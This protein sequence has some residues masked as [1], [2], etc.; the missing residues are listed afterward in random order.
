MKST[1][2]AEG[3]MILVM[4]LLIF[5]AY[6]R[7]GNSVTFDSAW[8]IHT[9]MSLLR[10]H[11]ADLD[12]YRG[13]I[14]TI[15]QTH[16]YATETINGHIYNFYPIGSSIIALPLVA[17]A[18]QFAR[19]VHGFDLQS[20]LLHSFA[21]PI[22]LLIASFLVAL[23]AVVLYRLARL[24]L[25]ISLALLL[26]FIFAFCTSAWSTASRVLWQHTASLLMLSL[27]LYLT[28]LARR[29][30]ALIQFISLPLALSYTIRP[31]NS[32]SIVVFTLY[33]FIAYR[34]YLVRYLLWALLVVVP[35]I[36]FNESIYHAL[37]SPYY[38]QYQE[39]SFA[40][41]LPALVGQ[42]LSPS[43]GLL[44]YSPVLLLSLFG[45]LIKI[46]RKQIDYLDVCL[47]S[48]VV[49]HWLAISIWPMWWGGWSYGPRLFT[50]MLA[51]FFYFMIP[52][53]V[54]APHWKRWRQAVLAVGTLLL[55]LWSF[56]IHYRGAT[57]PATLE[58]N[59]KPVYVD[60]YPDRLWDW[61]DAQFVRGLK[62]G[63]PTDLALSGIPILYFDSATYPLLGTNQLRLRRFDVS[64]AVIAPPEPGWLAISDQQVI[65]PELARLFAGV[66]AEAHF[67]TI[68]DHVPYSLYHFDLGQRLS[69][70]ALQSRQTVFVSS[71][72]QS[73]SLP[74]QLGKVVQ[75]IGYDV[76]PSPS[77][78]TTD[79]I[80]YW[81]ALQAVDAPLKLVVQ[82][83]DQTGQPLAQEERLDVASRSWLPGDLIAQV[84]RLTIPA[85]TASVWIEASLVNS[86]SGQRLPVMHNGQMVDRRVRLGLLET[87]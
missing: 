83:I 50:D 75:L 72:A 31:T 12:E 34:R 57:D 84:N 54:Q 5:T 13:F 65:N 39:F 20:Y 27:A 80:T 60:D 77:S 32:I 33:V 21:E 70:A 28:L 6:L 23:T 45:L 8:S 82:A 69:R 85:H 37:L 71:T 74:V 9:S 22:E 25:S 53:F 19:V 3:L 29:R 79:I 16:I 58:W 86:D 64:S 30:P 10:G 81:Q 68:T 2:L 44:I 17:V 11:N 40:T 59:R 41:V 55:A 63:P 47:V 56:A 24:Y 15:G 7:S 18:D 35:F 61:R 46:R 48:I 73:V 1:R 66:E 42:W 4:F 67:Q 51:Y 14:D 87:R 38:R 26:T 49:L 76:K 78:D 52:V 62:W 43:R 36:V